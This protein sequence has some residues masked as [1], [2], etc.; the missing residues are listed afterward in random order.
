[1]TSVIVNPPPGL[2]PPSEVIAEALRP[3]GYT[4]RQSADSGVFSYEAGVGHVIARNRVSVSWNPHTGRIG[5]YDFVAYD[6]SDFD[7][8][9]LD[10]IGLQV[11]HV[12]GEK[13][14][15]KR[16]SATGPYACLFGP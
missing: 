14:E 16:D 13:L 4:A 11:E 9:T 12:Y 5:L 3:L 2:P 15:F 6:E 1:M 10:A 7:R 8:K